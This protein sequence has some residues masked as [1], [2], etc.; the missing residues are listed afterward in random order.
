MSCQLMMEHCKANKTKVTEI[1]AVI[2]MVTGLNWVHNEMT[3][4]CHNSWNKSWDANWYTN[5]IQNKPTGGHNIWSRNWQDDWARNKFDESQHRVS[6]ANRGS[7]FR[8]N[9]QTNHVWNRHGSIQDS[10]AGKA[11]RRLASLLCGTR[12]DVGLCPKMQKANS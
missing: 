9:M 7:Q 4:G 5:W 2:G 6:R 8:Q 11:S 1:C 12:V 10:G 3:N